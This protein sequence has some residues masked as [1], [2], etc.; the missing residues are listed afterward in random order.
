M[1]SHTSAWMSLTRPA[2]PAFSSVWP[3][4]A[5][6]LLSAVTGNAGSIT[7]LRSAPASIGSPRGVPVPC[8][9][10]QASE[11]AVMLACCSA[12]SIRPAC[13]CPLGAERLT[14]RPSERQALP[15]HTTPLAA[16]P[17]SRT[18]LTLASDL[19]KPSARESQVLHRP[20]VEMAPPNA[21]ASCIRGDSMNETPEQ[22]AAVH[23]PRSKP[24]LAP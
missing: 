16:S 23:S 7:T 12:A 2:T 3:V 20:V 11:P 10:V 6:R 19:T 13:A 21:I 18:R 22:I 4:L 1:T 15:A 24:L 8:A 9:S 14:L 17:L 5:F